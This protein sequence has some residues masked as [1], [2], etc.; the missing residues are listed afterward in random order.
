MQVF[1]DHYGNSEYHYVEI[2][3]EKNNKKI[4]YNKTISE[5]MYYNTNKDTNSFCYPYLM[6]TPDYC[7]IKIWSANCEP[8]SYHLPGD[9]VIIDDLKFHKVVV[10]SSKN[11]NTGLSEPTT[12]NN[13]NRATEKYPLKLIPNPAGQFC[14]LNYS[15]KE[16]KQIQIAIYDAQGKLVKNILNQKH[17]AGDYSINIETA[18]LSEGVYFVMLSCDGISTSDRLVIMH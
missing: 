12:S 6:D 1:F 15:L 9:R 3:F 8:G 10:L 17:S 4:S 16:A 5:S 13:Y 2:I 18:N 7:T 14:I 11:V